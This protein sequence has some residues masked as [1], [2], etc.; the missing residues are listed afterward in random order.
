MTTRRILS[1][2]VVLMQML[3]GLSLAARAETKNARFPETRFAETR[4]A[5]SPDQVAR[6]MRAAGVAAAAERID[7]LSPIQTR[8]PNAALRLISVKHWQG[9]TLKAELRCSDRKACLP[10]YVLLRD[11]DSVPD[12]AV[13]HGSAEPQK[14]A[15]ATPRAHDVHIGDPA[16]LVFERQ[17]S[18]ITIRVICDQNGDRGQIIRVA[19]SDRKHSYKAEVIEPGLLKGAL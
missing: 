5:V 17:Q 19:S 16:I 18:R 13:V 4:F 10:F 15:S 14:S 12:L 8:Q 1:T 3:P 7:L 6:A 2:I 9:N 11:A